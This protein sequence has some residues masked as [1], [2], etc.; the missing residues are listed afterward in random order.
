MNRVAETYEVGDAVSFFELSY[1]HIYFLFHE[2]F[3]NV[4]QSLAQ[5]GKL[6]SGVSAIT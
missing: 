5:K 3:T 2:G 4:E 6:P 1:S